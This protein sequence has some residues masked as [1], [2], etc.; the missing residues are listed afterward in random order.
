MTF[1][2]FCALF[3]PGLLRDCVAKHDQRLPSSGSDHVL[4]YSTTSRSRV[5][6]QTNKSVSARAASVIP[7]N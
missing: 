6:P 5:S 2:P 7:G 4:Q 3:H 1:E